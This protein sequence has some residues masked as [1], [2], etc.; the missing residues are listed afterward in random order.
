MVSPMGAGKATMDTPSADP[1]A[2][3]AVPAAPHAQLIEMGIAIWKARAVYAAAALGLPDFLARGPRSAEELAA[4][5]KTHA[6]SLYRLLRALAACGLF[7]EPRPRLFAITP[8]GAALQS[9]APGAARSTILTLAGDWQWKAW[10]HFLHSLRTGEPGLKSSSGKSLFDFLAACPED[11]A[12]FDDAMVGMHGALGPALV[13]A[14]DFSKFASVVDVGGGTGRLLEALLGSDAKQKGV[15]FE[16]PATAAFARQHLQNT[17]LAERCEVIEGDFF[18]SVPP[19][20]EAYILSHVLHDWDDEQ[21]VSILRNCLRAIAPGGRLLIVEAVL[22]PGDAPHHGKMMDLL[23]LT[24]T[25]GKERTAAE[26]AD[27]L[28]A[29]NFALARVIPTS[30]HQSIVEAVPA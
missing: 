2:P 29:A 23:M 11:G 17:G 25:G 4:E 9:G 22:P 30:T 10:D 28:A 15:L 20:H 16:Q 7:R 5:T 24:V 18:E 6:P 21:C 8:L 3:G 1:A 12:R 27:L 14:Y 19:G 13:A 26:F